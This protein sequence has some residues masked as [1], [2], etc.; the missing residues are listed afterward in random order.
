MGEPTCTE[1]V[2]FASSPVRGEIR[3]GSSLGRQ[4]RYGSVLTAYQQNFGISS[5]RRLTTKLPE[6]EIGLLLL[7]VYFSRVW[8]ASLLFD[9][10]SI[11]EKYRAAAVPEH[12]LLSIFALAS[13]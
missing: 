8:T 11:V 1:P 7:E 4:K 3:R 5:P 10:R 12:I 2:F 9:H 13:L 6:F